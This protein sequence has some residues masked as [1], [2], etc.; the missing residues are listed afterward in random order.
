MKG[1]IKRR[2]ERLSE[3]SVE[4]S[5]FK[6]FEDFAGFERIQRM[7]LIIGKNNSGKSALLD[8]IEA[9]VNGVAILDAARR[10]GKSPLVRVRQLLSEQALR[11]TFPQ[12]T[13]GGSIRATNHWEFGQQWV[14]KTFTY[15]LSGNARSLLEVEPPFGL[16]DSEQYLEALS[17]HVS[18]PLSGMSAS[19]L[20]SERDINSEGQGKD[21]RLSSTGRGATNVLRRILLTKEHSNDDLKRKIIEGFNEV[22]GPAVVLEDITLK[23]DESTELW[24]VYLNERGKGAIPLSASGSGL[25]TILLVL[26]HLFI[27][28][29]ISGK[30]AANYI[31]LFEELENNLHPDMQ[32]RL[33]NLINRFSQETGCLVFMTTHSSVCIDMFHKEDDVQFLHV[34]QQ[35][36]VSSVE[37]VSSSSSRY[38]LLDDLGVRASDLLQANAVIW[39]EGPSDR[40]YVN[41]WI[42][43][44]SEGALKESVHYQC[45]FYGG[46]LLSHVSAA[47]PITDDDSFVK[48][49]GVNRN[50]IVIMDSDV[51]HEGGE[52]NQTKA[53]VL[54]EVKEM[55]GCAWITAGREI[56]NYIPHDVLQKVLSGKKVPAKEKW[57]SVWNAIDVVSPGLG[58]KL[59]K[60]KPQFAAEVVK[61]M[62]PA[63]GQPFDLGD[64]VAEVVR[65]LRAWNGIGVPR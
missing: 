8:L 64:R 37:S 19:R 61:N 63:D 39:V 31:F 5:G 52:I 11:H 53:R 32:R 58:E 7:N 49:L 20:S 62:G 38:R 26:C 23:H 60:Q 24:E 16:N 55:G 35:G 18:E 46:K 22:L 59:S 41:H 34:T 15:V 12:T 56:E 51:K 10:S 29:V 25:K 21:F 27:V 48:L 1:E 43:L 4:V 47:D 13:H 57:E 42:N 9:S 33:L 40:I 50:C 17:S 36:N 28:P 65:Y 30:C 54:E 44:A 6:C 14:G 3:T 45:V 2:A